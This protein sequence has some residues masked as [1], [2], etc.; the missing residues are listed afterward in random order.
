[1]LLLRMLRRL[2]ALPFLYIALRLL[3][4][5]DTFAHASFTVLFTAME[6]D[7]RIDRKEVERRRAKALA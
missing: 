1:M 2:L 3:P 6:S 7:N 5:R 4:R